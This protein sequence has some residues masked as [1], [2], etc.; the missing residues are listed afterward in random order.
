MTAKPSVFNDPVNLPGVIMRQ[1]YVGA[2]YL[3]G[4]GYDG[5]GLE[6]RTKRIHYRGDLVL[7]AGLKMD[8]NAV[9][10][11]RGLLTTARADKRVTDAAFNHAMGLH[12]VALAVATVMDCRPLTAE[13]YARNLWWDEAENAKKPRWAWVLFNVRALRPFAVDGHQGFLRVNK[14]LVTEAAMSDAECTQWR[15]RWS[16]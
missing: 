14:K 2:V 5:K 4:L 6:S 3:H 8:T 1:P 15:A 10:R 7:C 12:G 11:V 9:N 16:A 13:D